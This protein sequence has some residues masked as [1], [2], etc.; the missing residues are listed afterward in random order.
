MSVYRTPAQQGAAAPAGGLPQ[1]H[2]VNSPA[3]GDFYSASVAP[4]A[5]NFVVGVLL[6]YESRTQ[7]PGASQTFILENI[8]PGAGYRFSFNFPQLMFQCHDGAGNFT[9]CGVVGYYDP[10][11]AFAIASTQPTRDILCLLRGRQNG[12]PRLVLDV[13]LNGVRLGGD[14]ICAA[15]GM[16][17]SVGSLQVGGAI[18]GTIPMPN[19]SG[20]AG[21]AYFEG[22]VTD[23]Q[24]LAYSDQCL[25]EADL[26]EAPWGWD[27]RWSAKENPPGATWIDSSGGVDLTRSG[28]PAV[29]QRY[30]RPA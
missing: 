2:L 14:V 8:S 9:D 18:G 5:D 15:A 13:T 11:A 19:G 30:I 7:A 22:T 10:G 17:P 12:T 16:T 1:V 24:M 3:A 25:G 28:A 20:I 27:N 23:A 29:V 26:L 6:R 21:V 4:G